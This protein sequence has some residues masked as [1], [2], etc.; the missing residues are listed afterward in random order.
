MSLRSVA[1]ADHMLPIQYSPIILPGATA[2]ELENI[3]CSEEFARQGEDEIAR[4]EAHHQERCQVPTGMNETPGNEMFVNGEQERAGIQDGP[5]NEGSLEQQNKK[6]LSMMLQ[7]QYGMPGTIGPKGQYQLPWSIV[8][9]R[10][11]KTCDEHQ[12]EET[13]SQCIPKYKGRALHDYEIMLMLLEQH[14]KKRLLMARQEQDVLA[15]NQGAQWYQQ[16]DVDETGEDEMA[17]E[18]ESEDMESEEMEEMRG[19]FEQ[20]RL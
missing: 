8:E 13:E 6:R 19:T 20:S 10:G 18:G 5:E 14:N 11:N 15:C 4:T 2:D 3:D 9:T 17:I 16:M 1:H 12:Q 7:V